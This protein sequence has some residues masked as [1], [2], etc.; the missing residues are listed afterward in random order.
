MKKLLA[1]LAVLGLFVAANAGV[2]SD[3]SCHVGNGCVAEVTPV[4][5][6]ALAGDSCHV[7]GCVSSDASI[8]KSDQDAGNGC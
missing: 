7:N 2:V 8:G 6:N 3:D 1:V 5:H 4:R